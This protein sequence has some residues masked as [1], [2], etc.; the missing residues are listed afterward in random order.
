MQ[1]LNTVVIQVYITLENLRGTPYVVCNGINIL[2]SLA[3]FAPGHLYK[4]NQLGKVVQFVHFN[5]RS[6]FDHLTSLNN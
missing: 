2:F 3:S 5:C 1:V 4:V 6:Y